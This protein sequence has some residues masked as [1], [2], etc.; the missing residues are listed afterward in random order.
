MQEYLNVPVEIV[1]ITQVSVAGYVGANVEDSLVSLLKKAKGNQEVA[2]N[3]I[4]VFNEID[5]KGTKDNG[6]ISGR[7]V[8]NSLLPFM[9]GT[10]YTVYYG[11]QKYDFDTSKLTIFAT[12]AFSDVIE[13]KKKKSVGFIKNDGLTKDNNYVFVTLDDLNEHGDIPM[14]L[15]GRF[16]HILSLP[17]PSIKRLKRILISSKYS[18]LYLKQLIFLKMNILLTCTEE[19]IDEVAKKA[20][21][22]KTGARS[23]NSII[24]DTLK[25]VEWF[26]LT[27]PQEY[28][29]ILLTEETIVNNL[30]CWVID[31]NGN[32]YCLKD[33]LNNEV[34]EEQNEKT[35]IHIKKKH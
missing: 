16:T 15:L 31:K 2:E 18:P 10:I 8:L 17:E 22:M 12:G 7:G 6:D 9:E 19:F 29:E 3:G 23:L 33:I 26:L 4:I 24:E 21:S 27:H 1:D 32:R 30:I 5:K 13:M 14:E 25:E 35:L 20:Y 28:K 34:L 11:G